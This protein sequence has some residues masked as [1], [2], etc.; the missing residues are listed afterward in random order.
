MISFISV[1][2]ISHVIIKQHMFLIVI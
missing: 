1:K 2:H